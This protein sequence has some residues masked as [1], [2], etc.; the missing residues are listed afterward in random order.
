MKPLIATTKLCLLGLAI[1]WATS[2]TA[3]DPFDE[4]PLGAIAPL[5]LSNT[6]LSSGTVKAYRPWFEIG[7]WQG[8]LV[9]YSISALGAITT[10]VDFSGTSPSNPGPDAENWSALFT[11]QE[12]V[13]ADPDYWRDGRKIITSVNGTQKSFTWNTAEP[14]KGLDEPNRR[15]L[16]E[17]AVDDGDASS[18]ILDYIRG[19]QSN[20]Y[21]ALLAMRPRASALGDII[22]SNPTY[23]AAPNGLRTDNEYARWAGE[24]GRIDREPRVYVGAN[25]GMLHVFDAADGSEV[26]AYV[27]SMLMGELNKLKARPFSH[28]YFVDGKL[29]AKDAFFAKG[30][31]GT[32]TWHTV[33]VGTLGGGGRGVFALDI[34]N[35]DLSNEDATSGSD[36]KVLWEKDASAD[37]DLGDSFSRATIVQLNDDAWYAVFGNGYNSENGVAKLYLVNIGTAAVTKISTSSGTAVSPNGLST[38][39]LLDTDKDGKADYAYAGDIDGNMWKFDL[40]AT[41]AGLWSLVS[42][43]L[44]PAQTAGAK[45]ITSAPRVALHPNSGYIVYFATGRLF[46]EADVDDSSVQSMYGIWD[47]GELP[48]TKATQ[49]LLQVNLD[50]FDNEYTTGG[51]SEYIGVYTPDVGNVIWTTQHGWQV[52]FPSGYR[53]LEAIQLRGARAKVTIHNPNNGL[54]KNALVEASIYDGGA[55]T[56]PIFDLSGD[57]ILDDVDLFDSNGDGSIN[58]DDSE[59]RPMAW[60]RQDGVMSQVSIA[61]VANGID[62]L[63][64]NYLVPPL[65]P[66][67]DSGFEGGHID[68]DTWNNTADFGGYSTKH[69]HEYD[70][71]TGRVFVDFFDLNVPTG[72]PRP[73][74][75]VTNQVEI[76]DTDSSAIAED[77]KFVVLVANADLSAGSTFKIG[78]KTWNVAEYQRELHRALRAWD[79]TV[80]DSVPVVQPPPAEQPPVKYVGDSLSFTWGEIQGEDGGNGTISHNFDHQAIISGGLHPTQTVCVRDGAYDT[81]DP[82]P[83]SLAGRWRNGALTTQLVKTSHFTSAS[84]IDDVYVQRP[85][86]LDRDISTST[87]DVELFAVDDGEEYEMGGIIAK[88]GD[89]H[90]WESAIFWHF[91]KL[92]AL[93]Y[94]N[95]PCYGDEGWD[96]A[97]ELEQFGNPFEKAFALLEDDED[98]LLDGIDIDDLEDALSDSLVCSGQD[99][100]DDNSCRPLY[101]LLVNLVKLRPDYDVDISDANGGDDENLGVG[102]ITPGAASNEGPTA[103]V[104]FDYGRASWTDVVPK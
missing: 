78:D 84:A 7:A 85:D 42:G 104:E 57:G 16:D 24:T 23:V 22:H 26:Y 35:P 90:I 62:T 67:A 75:S 27:P 81:F 80:P 20:E 48:P 92:Y 51:K 11:M 40:T 70:K 6:D 44:H 49:S 63:F 100:S 72:E 28:R 43:P 30:G 25:D 19:D 88:T 18:N 83:D 21:P 17:D 41:T 66:S 82:E 65:P 38:P 9:E 55:H 94:G 31:S 33:L 76:N 32:A 47:S 39:T 71:K 46:T 87:G 59:D 61:R 14:L 13:T 96:L 97:V 73:R 98:G 77:E 91:G 64:L 58:R 101:R 29:T 68:V 52:D 53:V 5:V 2:S 10:S 45:A 74:R 102:T 50:A 95:K 1:A 8:D 37:N 60:Q 54:R 4:Q 89:E 15:L 79:A 69:D 99:S 56:G 93:V 34:T 103:G 36:I 86:D 3:A 12:A